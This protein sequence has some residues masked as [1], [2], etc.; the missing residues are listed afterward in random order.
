MELRSPLWPG[1]RRFAAGADVSASGVT[2]VV[3]SRRAHARA[4]VRIEW[5]AHAP[6]PRDAMAGAEI[7]DRVALV[8][9]LRDVFGQL[10]RAC[11]AAL[12]RCAMA[13]PAG[14]TV[15]AS[16][17]FAHFQPAA[18]LECA[19]GEMRLLAALEPAVL[20]EAERIAGVERHELAVD[21]CIDPLRGAAEGADARDARA[22]RVTITSAPRQHL[23]A[24]IECAAMAGITLCAMDGDAHAALRAM[25]YAASLELSPDD[26]YVALWVGPDGVHGWYLADDLVARE[27]RYPALEHADLVE[28]LRDL[29]NGQ[30][31]GCA[32]IAG[33]LRMLSGARVSMADIGRVLGCQVLPFECATFAEKGQTLAANLLHEPACAVAFGLA[34]RGVSE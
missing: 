28:A 1:M 21:W 25:R 33:D 27:I 3:L 20:A 31:A 7:V 6:L 11:D 13:L 5:L 23:E 10:P 22:C 14:A 2:L 9:A 15:V 18:P 19:D 17:P 12:L 29:L 26:A 4:P 16:L 32:L 8:A 34:L 30:Q 24:R